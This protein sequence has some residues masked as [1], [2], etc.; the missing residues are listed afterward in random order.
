MND[1]PGLQGL[2]VFEYI[3]CDPDIP[4]ITVE[5]NKLFLLSVKIAFGLCH[6]Q[7]S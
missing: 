3:T 4:T 2:R 7:I 5:M 1:P 6:V